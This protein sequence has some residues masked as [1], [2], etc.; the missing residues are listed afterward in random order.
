MGMNMP[1][2][3]IRRREALDERMKALESSVAAIFSIMHM[4]RRCM[5]YDDIHTFFPPEQRLQLPQ[6]PFHLIFRELVG[7]PIIPTGASQTQDF[8][9]VKFNDPGMNIKA[10]PGWFGC[11]ADVVIA[12]YIV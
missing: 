10:S 2:N 1:V 12:H 9:M 7:P 11:I 6:R 8:D 3:E 4:P 5:G